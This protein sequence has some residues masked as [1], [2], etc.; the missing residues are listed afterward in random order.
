MHNYVEM[1]RTHTIY[2]LTNFPHKWQWFGIMFT[3]T[4]LHLVRSILGVTACAVTCTGLPSSL[5]TYRGIK[6]VA[7][8]SKHFLPD[9]PQCY[10]Q[11]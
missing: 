4:V 3:S 7:C 2:E 8:L 1:I 9:Y 5:D 10:P 6:R 11:S